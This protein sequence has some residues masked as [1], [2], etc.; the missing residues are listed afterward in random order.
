MCR[1]SPRLNICVVPQDRVLFNNTTTNNIHNSRVAASNQAEQRAAM[2]AD[3]PSRTLE[4]LQ[5][6]ALPC[7]L[8]VQQQ[9][10]LWNN[11]SEME[12]KY[13]F[14]FTQVCWNLES[15]RWQ[16]TCVVPLNIQKHKKNKLTSN[17]KLTIGLCLLIPQDLSTMLLTVRKRHGAG[18]QGD[19][20]T[21]WRG[22]GV[23]GWRS[24]R[25]HKKKEEKII[26]KSDS[27]E[28]DI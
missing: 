1:S 20:V 3:K 17:V 14:Y 4:L 23:T 5:G 18:W 21:G 24:L 12:M 16:Q 2:A 22:D 27:L 15:G 26:R 25:N 28:K 7:G 19:R 10:L 13:L 11:D 6:Q 9:R 8:D